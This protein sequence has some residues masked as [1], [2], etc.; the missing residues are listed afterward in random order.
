MRLS[1]NPPYS[2]LVDFKEAKADWMLTTN[3][4]RFLALDNAKAVREVIITI[5]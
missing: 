4:E 1:D 5:A 2:R 3:A